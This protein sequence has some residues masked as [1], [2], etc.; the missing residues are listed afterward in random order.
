VLVD[1]RDRGGYATRGG[2]FHVEARAFPAVWGV[3]NTFGEVHGD[4][5]TYLTPGGAVRPTLAL[6]VGGK[7]VFGDYPFQEAAYIGGHTTVRG[8]RAERF[9]G[10]GSLYGNAELRLPLG[11][12]SGLLPGEFG[13][14]GLGDVGRVFL[15]G[16]SSRK[17]HTAAG[18]GVWFSFFSRS[19]TLSVAVAKSEERTGLYVDAGFM[20]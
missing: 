14:F 19:N 17:W 13:I 8:L 20:F 1:R 5:S 4:A 10:D 15:E 16:E 3:R 6:R 2:L 11:R 12:V 7:R 18:A 9:G